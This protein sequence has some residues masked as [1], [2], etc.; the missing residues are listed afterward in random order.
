MHICL[1]PYSPEVWRA[2]GDLGDIEYVCGVSG[3][4]RDKGTGIE[5]VPSLDPFDDVGICREYGYYLHNLMIGE[6]A[7]VSV[8]CLSCRAIYDKARARMP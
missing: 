6:V 5:G 2:Q 4:V 3:V 8:Q 1:H 7:S